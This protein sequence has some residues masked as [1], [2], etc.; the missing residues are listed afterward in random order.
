MKTRGVYQ[1]SSSGQEKVTAEELS[2]SFPL[3]CGSGHVDDSTIAEIFKS[4]LMPQ[5]ERIAY[6]ELTPKHL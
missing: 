4:A 3:Y 1:Q 6:V 5:N 2:T